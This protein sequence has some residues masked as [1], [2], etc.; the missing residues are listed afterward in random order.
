MC[1]DCRQNVLGEFT[2]QAN[3][4][5]NLLKTHATRVS[6]KTNLCSDSQPPHSHVVLVLMAKF[7]ICYLFLSFF[8][9]FLSFFKFQTISTIFDQKRYIY[10]Y[11]LGCSHILAPRSIFF[12]LHR[13]AV[14]AFD[15]K[16][17]LLISPGDRPCR[18]VEDWGAAHL[19]PQC[20][21]T[22]PA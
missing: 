18:V 19:P 16:I 10:L 22:L 9:V 14:Y 8:Y 21:N 3:E 20:A 6:A 5:P 2:R 15:P 11:Q 13:Q 12:Y 7:S 17:Y 4:P 1:L